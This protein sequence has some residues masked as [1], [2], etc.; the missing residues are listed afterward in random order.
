[1]HVVLCLTLYATHF[2]TVDGGI[3]A[4]APVFRGAVKRVPV[5]ERYVEPIIELVES[6]V[7]QGQA[8]SCPTEGRYRGR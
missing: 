2:Q 6:V 1:M 7:E 5:F 4:A 3:P 8:I